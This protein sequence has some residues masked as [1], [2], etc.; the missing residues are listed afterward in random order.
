MPTLGST[1]NRSL[2]VCLHASFKSVARSHPKF[3][4]LP[5]NCCNRLAKSAAVGK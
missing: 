3:T 4:W 2:N 1:V 5:E